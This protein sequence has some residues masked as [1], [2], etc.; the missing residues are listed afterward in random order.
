[1][2]HF[3]HGIFQLTEAFS[4]SYRGWFYFLP[5]IFDTRFPAN[6]YG[7]KIAYLCGVK[8]ISAILFAILAAAWTLSAQSVGNRV[9]KGFPMY[10]EVHDGDTTYFD[11]L[12]PIWV[13]PRGRGFKGGGDWRKD[14]RL[15]Y[16]FNKVYPYALVGRKLMAQV[17]STIA[18]DATKKSQRTQYIKSVER[19]LLDLFS[20]DIKKMT[21]TQGMVLMR[22][23]DRECGLSPYDI[24]K[25]YE[26]GFAANFW[27]VIAKLFSHD[28]KTRYEP[29]G[30]DRRIEE[31]VQI[32][33]SGKWDQFYYSIFWEYPTKTVIKSDRLTSE[34]KKSPSKQQKSRR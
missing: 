26:G 7:A 5:N 24:I 29:Q 32:W 19:E 18:A 31:L 6:F 34:I 13:F 11:N 1:M 12:E 23:V 27:Q 21:I 4:G 14:Y 25:E 30:R 33:D 28:L 2:K 15:V 20:K 17:D 8:R 9:P 22:L 3:R 16:N 10:Y